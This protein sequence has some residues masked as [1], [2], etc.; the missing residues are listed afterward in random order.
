[1]TAPRVAVEDV[2]NPPR[3]PG[4]A[5]TNDRLKSAQ[6]SATRVRLSRFALAWCAALFLAAS[7]PYLIATFAPPAGHDGFGTIMFVNDFAQYEAAMAEGARSSS[8]LVHDH[9]TPEPHEPAFMFPLYVAIGKLAALLDLPPLALYRAAEGLGRAVLVL[10]IAAVAASF[11]RERRLALV[12]A[13]LGSGL[14]LWAVVAQTVVG[15]EQPYGGNGSYELNP[16]ALLFAPPHVTLGMALT[17]AIITLL[18]QAETHWSRVRATLLG[19]ATLGLC[20]LHPFNVVTLVVVSA[21]LLASSWLEPSS[22]GHLRRW[23][24]G[25]VLAALTLGLAA[26]PLVLYNGATF[27]AS[28]FWGRA[29]G[30][31]NVLPSPAPHELIV[32]LGVFLVLG[33][34]AI[35][36]LWRRGGDHRRLAIVLVV[37]LGAMYAPVP[38]QRR[39]AF[40]LAPLLGIAVGAALADW[41]HSQRPALRLHRLGRAGVIAAAL[42]SS[43]FI[44]AGFVASAAGNAPIPVYRASSDLREVRDWLAANSTVDDVSLSSWDVANYLAGALPGRA[45]GGHPVATLRAHERRTQASLMF[46]SPHE[47]ETAIAREHATLLI[48]TGSTEPILVE[49]ALPIFQRGEVTVARLMPASGQGG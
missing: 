23:S 14:G 32:D 19:V 7:L 27:A 39:L 47:Q 21:A 3:S 25:T 45:A 16:Y 15:V 5:E 26:A 13:T 20:L 38:F 29:Y 9:F 6:E 10:A 30:E 46:S 31:Q 22:R 8:W 42:G 33:I 24:R 35:A 12:F 44:Y 43:I 48:S 28:A 11:A 1:M 4:R 41:F 34:P 40:G 49:G 36:A 17:L 18:V 37:M 2:A